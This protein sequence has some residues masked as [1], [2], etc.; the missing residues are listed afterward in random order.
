MKNI[1]TNIQTTKKKRF[2]D[3]H[4]EKETQTKTQNHVAVLEKKKICISINTKILQ[5]SL[6]AEELSSKLVD[7]NK[8]NTIKLMEGFRVVS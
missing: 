7:R 5:A 3:P 1:G 2:L 4:V 6:S 8:K